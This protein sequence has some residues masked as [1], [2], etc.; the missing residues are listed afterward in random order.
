MPWPI[1]LVEWML[2]SMTVIAAEVGAYGLALGASHGRH[3]LVLPACACLALA[4]GSFVLARRLRRRRVTPRLLVGLLAVFWAAVVAVG[5]DRVLQ[6]M[7]PSWDLGSFS[8]A[9]PSYVAI[10]AVVVALAWRSLRR[11]LPGRRGTDTPD[12]PTL[13]YARGSLIWV[14]MLIP[15]L[16]TSAGMAVLVPPA[17]LTGSGHSPRSRGR[18]CR[19]E[20]GPEGA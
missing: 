1:A 11:W 2:Y 7:F 4:P 12:R 18:V 16:I 19:C 3:E 17:E 13:G 10:S 5:M 8:A 6:L 9:I 15:A 14:T 20:R